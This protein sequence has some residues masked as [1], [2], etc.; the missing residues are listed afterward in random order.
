MALLRWDLQMSKKEE[1]LLFYIS[2][3]I[4]FV[5]MLQLILEVI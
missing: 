4:L 2:M 1:N 5:F 3:L